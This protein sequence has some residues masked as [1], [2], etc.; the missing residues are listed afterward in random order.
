MTSALVLVAFAV[1]AGT[2]GVSALTQARWTARAPRLAIAAWQALATSVLL[3]IAAA[4]AALAIGFQHVRGDLAQLF[5]VC[6]E[7]LK[8]GY[9]SPGGTVVATLGLASL[10]ILATRLTCFVTSA[11][12]I[13]LHGRRL[14]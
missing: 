7:N 14:R 13:L 4:G 3:S 9:A 1:T 6:V 10:S 12:R 5:N 8:H 2:W 11:P